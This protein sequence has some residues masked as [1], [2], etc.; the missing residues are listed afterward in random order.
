MALTRTALVPLLLGTVLLGGCQ[1]IF[2]HRT[3]AASVEATPEPESA[4]AYSDRQ[5]AFGK[6]SLDYRQYGLAIIA[7][8]KAQHDPS[9][10]AEAHNGLAIAYAQIGRADL[11]ERYFKQ[12]VDEAPQE[13]RYMANLAR[14]YQGPAMAT[15]ALPRPDPV[16]VA[17][18]QPETLAAPQVAAMPIPRRRQMG[19]V[20][21]ELPEPGMVRISANEVRI[22]TPA[23]VARDPRRPSGRQVAVKQ[24]V[25]RLNPNYP[26]RV[27]LDAPGLRTE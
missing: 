16:A 25:R 17:L 1:S 15:A 18:A 11:A 22:T 6:E 26:V 2:G 19:F 27:R 7:L 8:R 4:K 14:F 23:P 3:A 9:N 12:A 5:L 10:A 21:V 24:P 13:A 20:R